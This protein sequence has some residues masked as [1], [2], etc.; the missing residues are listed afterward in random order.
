MN[1]Q[2]Q[3][4]IGLAGLALALTANLAAA[5][6]PEDRDTRTVVVR[7]SDLDLT[8]P[9]DAHRLYVRIEDAAR[10]VCG[11]RPMTVNLMVAA[12][13]RRCTKRL[14]DEA[15]AKVRATQPPQRLYARFG[16][17]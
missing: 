5:A 14:V 9:Q 10:T 2:R 3:L 8:Q 16:D 13:Y 12:A 6:T 7:F 11:D 15:V 4:L 17:R 1:S